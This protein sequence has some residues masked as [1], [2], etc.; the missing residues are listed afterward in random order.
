MRDHTVVEELMAARALDGLER[1][2]ESTLAAERS[3]HGEGCE[4]CLR[5]EV[6]YEEVAG[7]LAFA[8][9]PEEVRAGL[10][11]E[12]VAR[13]RSA[14]EEATLRAA[15]PAARAQ[16]DRP[17]SGVARLPRLLVAAAAAVL[18]IAAGSAGYL[19]AP[20]GDANAIALSRILEEGGRVVPLGGTAPGNLQIAYKPGS[21]EVFLVGSGLD[22]PA[23]GKTLELWLFRGK[24]PVSGGCFVPRDGQLLE[25][26]QADLSG[27]DSMAVTVEPSSC[28]SAPSTQP[29]L[30]A[31]L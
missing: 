26:V 22:T 10:E 29:I 1:S 6:E 17:P 20:R 7:R 4:E 8:L 18:V 13:A 28:P 3:S 2:E 15:A 5:I 9:E 16:A 21:R 27:A 31:P 30:S 14:P 11:D 25:Y 24:T 12:L 23:D 19:I